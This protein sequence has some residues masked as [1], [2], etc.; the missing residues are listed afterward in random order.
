MPSSS[1]IRVLVLHDDDV[2]DPV[3][4]KVGH[5]R[6]AAAETVAERIAAK[7]LEKA[8]VHAVAEALRDELRVLQRSEAL[9]ALVAADAVG[10]QRQQNHPAEPVRP[11]MRP[12]KIDVTIRRTGSAR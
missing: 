4:Q 8:H 5:A 7:Q 10:Q 3:L 11:F 6:A 12:V 9:E 1:R 2:P